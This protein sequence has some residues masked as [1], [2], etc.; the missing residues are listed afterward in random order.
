MPIHTEEETAISGTSLCQLVSDTESPCAEKVIQ[1][2]SI[3]WRE[4]VWFIV[5]CDTGTGFLTRA[6]LS[7]GLTN[8]LILHSD[9]TMSVFLF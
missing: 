3:S 4:T 9:F 7:T 6:A 8:V 5:S 1:T 2:M